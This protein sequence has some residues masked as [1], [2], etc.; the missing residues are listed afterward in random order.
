MHDFPVSLQTELVGRLLLAVLLGSVLGWERQMGRHP[1]GLRTHMLVSLGAAAY[2]IAGA[3]GGWALLG[4]GVGTVEDPGRVAAQIITGIGFLGAGTIWR[5]SGDEGV[6]RGLTTAA[7]IWVAASIGMLTGYGLYVL[8]AGTAILSLAVLRLIK[9]VERAPRA[10]TG[11]VAG[12]LRRRPAHAT[13]GA[14]YQ[15][16]RAPAVVEAPPRPPVD[17][18]FESGDTTATLAEDEP[19]AIAVVVA[20]ADG[21][22]KRGDRERTGKK[23]RKGKKGR[24]GKRRDLPPEELDEISDAP[25]FPVAGPTRR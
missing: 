7:S 23:L 11:V 18:Q 13:S 24:K 9:G 21:T 6:I 17:G 12:R 25:D 10:L 1:A 14:A 20:G 4:G 15:P 22:G 19:P 8:A 16:A 5:S 3:Y 2:T